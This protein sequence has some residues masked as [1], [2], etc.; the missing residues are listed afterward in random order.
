VVARAIGDIPQ[1][2]NFAIKA[3]VAEVFLRSQGIEPLISP[4]TLPQ[5]LAVPDAVEK[6]RPYTFIVECDPNRPTA[7][8]RADAA[9]AIADAREANRR[10]SEQLEEEQ[11]RVAATLETERRAAT[12]KAERDREAAEQR[13]ASRRKAEQD[14]AQFW[15][16]HDMA[17]E[18]CLRPTGVNIGTLEWSR[19]AAAERWAACTAAGTITRHVT[20]SPAP[21]AL[22]DQY[23]LVYVFRTV[24]YKGRA[25]DPSVQAD[26]VELVRMDNNCFFSFFFQP[27]VHSLNAGGALKCRIQQA[28]ESG[29]T[30][31]FRLDFDF[32]NCFKMTP[33]D[34]REAEP[35][36][37]KL[38]PLDP[39]H[40]RNAAVRRQ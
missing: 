33:V 27:G 25:V 18:D 16:S 38:K 3:E 8:Q 30:Y 31:Y 5:Q 10:R 24:K 11:R 9:L 12:L 14:V 2:V 37:A 32:G 40:V 34:S 23:A 7:Q 1:N 35:R 21:V 13:E 20:P 4:A 15:A 17:A 26:G 29:K 6:A 22:E 28:F 36:M 39:G 19:M